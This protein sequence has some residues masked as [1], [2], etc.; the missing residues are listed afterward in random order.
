MS[1][2][3]PELAAT[4]L[5]EAIY[6]TDKKACEKYGITDR[7]L[8]RYR[9]RLATDSELSAIVRTKKEKLD[10]A[11]ADEL[12]IALRRGIQVIGECVEAVSQDEKAK[13][14]ANVIHAI[15]GALKICADM[16]LTSRV[17]DAR[18]SKGNRQPDEVPG[19]VSSQP[20]NNPSAAV[21]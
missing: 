9:Q 15:S 10:E 21:N 8:R 18:Y 5:L 6:T 12:P 20:V 17:I 2:Y 19:Q 11:W 1:K 3:D 14:D 13:K 4:V 16:Q 7:T